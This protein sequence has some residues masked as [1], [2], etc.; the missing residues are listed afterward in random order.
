MHRHFLSLKSSLFD[1]GLRHPREWRGAKS[2]LMEKIIRVLQM[3][4][5]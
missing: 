4:Y 1:N 2:D 5:I 3:R